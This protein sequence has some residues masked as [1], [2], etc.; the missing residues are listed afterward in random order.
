MTGSARS[1][2]IGIAVV[3]APA[4]GFI[5][6]VHAG[7]ALTPTGSS[8]PWDPAG[9]ILALV[10]GGAVWPPA[11]TF[12]AA[13]IVGIIC[14]GTIFL[15]LR[16]G[17]KHPTDR[18]NRHLATS[19]ELAALKMAARKKEAARLHPQAASLPPGQRIGRVVGRSNPGWIFQGWRDLS[20][21]IFG[22]GRGKTSTQ[23]I[24]HMISAPGAAVMTTNKIDGVAE[25]LAGRTGDGTTSHYIF[26]S[27]GIYRRSAQPDFTFNPLD[28]IEKL[29]DAQELAAIFEAS[30][31][32]RTSRDGDPQF[33][34]AGRGLFAC[35]LLA[36]AKAV[37][38]LEIVFEWLSKRNGREA[39]SILSEH[40]RFGPV[41]AINGVLGQ[42]DRTSGSVFATAQRMAA[43]LIDDDLL[44]WTTPQAGIRTFDPEAFITSKDTLILLSKEGEGSGGAILTSL[45]RAICKRAERLAQNNKG[46]LPVP[47]VMELDECANIV[48]WPELPSVYSFYGSLGIILSTYFQSWTQ[49][50]GSFGREGMQT[51]WDAATSRVYGGGS[52]DDMWLKS[53]SSLIGERD[54]QI[55]N[56]SSGRN[57][58]STNTNTRRVPI[59]DVATL[60]ALPEWRA[61]VFSSKS[62]PVMIETVPWFKEPALSSLVYG[63]QPTDV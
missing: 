58:Y 57:H 6:T 33:D 50:V 55:K 27:Q 28:E 29:S 47:L 12:L 62:R 14:G 9:I 8:Y 36:A 24:P 20:V 59:L 37:I 38:P 23:V 10:R 30:T 40:G 3:A 22:P 44:A 2:L 52:G 31:L 42:P 15:N 16:G 61:V 4:V 32:K 21:C 48:R 19:G 34:E 11:S 39:I 56:S 54:E 7:N 53:L 26:D 60:G 5:F 1:K 13:I 17:I 41:K 63:K 43:A 35:F 45:V 18:A 25:V 46:R 51:M 49:G